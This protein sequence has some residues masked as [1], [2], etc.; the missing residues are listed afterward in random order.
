MIYFF[1]GRFKEFSP[2]WL[3]LEIKNAPTIHSPFSQSMADLSFPQ[4]QKAKDILLGVAHTT[5]HQ[6]TI[7]ENE[8]HHVDLAIKRTEATH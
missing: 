5:D 6:Q 4:H 2:T 1:L 7:L 3:P 8:R